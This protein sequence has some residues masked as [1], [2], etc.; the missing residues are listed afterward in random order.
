LTVASRWGEEVDGGD[1][2]DT[3]FIRILFDKCR[4][5]HRPGDLSRSIMQA[6]LMA[7]T[8]SADIR[9]GWKAIEESQ[10]VKGSRGQGKNQNSKPE[11]RN[12]LSA[13]QNYKGGSLISA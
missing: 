11:T 3:S 4:K 6:A 2:Q 5:K 1:E 10:G 8:K 13:L 7:L 12:L 9:Q